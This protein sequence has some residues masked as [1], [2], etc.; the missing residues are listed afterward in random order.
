MPEFLP[1]SAVIPTRNRAQALAR[2]L[3]SLSDQRAQ[4]AE[5]IVVDASENAETQAIVEQRSENV[6]GDGKVIWRRASSAGAAAQRNEGIALA[7]QPFVLFC[8]DDVF[9]EPECLT[10][11]WTAITKDPVLGGV[12]VMIVNQRYQQPGRMSRLI[13]TMMNGKSAKTFAGKIIGPAINLLPED[14]EELP[15]VVAVEWLNLGCTIYRREALPSPPFES[16]FAGYSLMED[17]TLSLRV[18]ERGWKLANVRTARIFHDT[19]P[20]EHKSDVSSRAEMELINRHYVMTKVLKKRRFSD[21]VRLGGWELFQLAALSNSASG[22]K[23][24]WSHIAGRLRA[25]RK[26]VSG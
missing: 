23:Q 4:P 11:L 5:L 3:E 24:L 16:F 8:D 13:F 21:Y 10:R 19:Q 18:A 20:G 12:S 15:E 17:V 25:V 14:R 1:V 22:R 26:I 2:T 6:P 9:F 7:K